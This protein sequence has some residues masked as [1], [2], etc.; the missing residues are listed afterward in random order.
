MSFDPDERM[1]DGKTMQEEAR[2]RGRML[3]CVLWVVVGV[4]L[5]GVY[6]VAC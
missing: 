1:P 3:G 2:D 5:G 6:L 4:V